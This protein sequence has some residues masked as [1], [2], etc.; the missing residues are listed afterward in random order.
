MWLAISQSCAASSCMARTASIN[1][2]TAAC[3]V[4]AVPKACRAEKHVAERG[5]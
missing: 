4:A 5:A 3:G 2:P 1:A